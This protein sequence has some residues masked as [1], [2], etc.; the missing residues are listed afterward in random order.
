[1][2]NLCKRWLEPQDSTRLLLETRKERAK[3]QHPTPTKTSPGDC[4]NAVSPTQI[5]VA[6][7]NVP[8]SVIDLPVHLNENEEVDVINHNKPMD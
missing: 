3:V 6:W 5:T 8:E 4:N 2:G 1:M 7:S